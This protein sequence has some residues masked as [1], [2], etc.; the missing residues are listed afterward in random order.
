MAVL[1]IHC[2]CDVDEDVMDTALPENFPEGVS[3]CSAC[4]VVR[5]STVNGY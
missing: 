1:L 4:S 2:I 3:N 5:F